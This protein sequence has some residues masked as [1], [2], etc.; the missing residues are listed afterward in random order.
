[1]YDHAFIAPKSIEHVWLAIPTINHLKKDGSLA[2]VCEPSVIPLMAVLFPSVRWVMPDEEIYS[3]NL[4]FAIGE[5]CSHR[6]IAEKKIN[7]KYGWDAILEKTHCHF[8]IYC[9]VNAGADIWKPDYTCEYKPSVREFKNKTGLDARDFIDM[10][11]SDDVTVDKFSYVSH[12]KALLG[13]PQ[14]VI[15]PSDRSLI[16]ERPMSK[17]TRIVLEKYDNAPRCSVFMNTNNISLEMLDTAI[18]SVKATIGPNDDFTVISSNAIPETQEYLMKKDV[19]TMFI[20]ENLFVTN[21]NFA[22]ETTNA[23]Y[24]C[25]LNDDI[26]AE[27]GWLD[28]LIKGMEETRS[29]QAGFELSGGDF[30]ENEKRF[31]H[32][33]WGRCGSW[34]Y[35]DGWCVVFDRK[36]F[37]KHGGYSFYLWGDMRLIYG[38]DP[39]LSWK[40]ME[41]GNNLLAIYPP[42]IK[43]FRGKSK[44]SGAMLE[45]DESNNKY[46]FNRWFG[47]TL[48]GAIIEQYISLADCN[49]NLARHG[50]LGDAVTGMAAAINI[51]EEI[52]SCK[53]NIKPYQELVDAYKHPK[54]VVTPNDEGWQNYM[55]DIVD[56]NLTKN[57]AHGY[58]N[59]VG[60][61]AA[62]AGHVLKGTPRM[63]CPDVEP[64]PEL[65]RIKY[66]VIQPRSFSNHQ[67]DLT[68]EA[69]LKVIKHLKKAGLQVVVSGKKESTPATLPVTYMFGGPVNYCRVIRGATIMLGSESAGAHIA[70]GYNIPTLMWIRPERL[71]YMWLF[72]YPGWTK[73]ICM[74]NLNEVLKALEVML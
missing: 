10:L 11:W 13:K 14:V 68:N 7:P 5:L 40:L 59:Y 65:K 1:M 15:W 29:V 60:N 2:V 34:Q 4:Y 17:D 16:L 70:A 22:A 69:M 26:K 38:D 73:T 8:A 58:K 24:V 61:M 12:I 25:F 41:D 56:L 57:D 28:I 45:A 32:A 64:L 18:E 55:A 42:R 20:R 35:V 27:A 19:K 31:R 50:C 67:N 47:K 53:V 39:D 62:A 9:L 33:G 23:K 6:V 37:L 43:H 21:Y 72:D 71:E 3:H 36:M 51:A 44:K 74:N 54:I 48:K 52:G 63:I 49:V 30:D 66:A 46:L